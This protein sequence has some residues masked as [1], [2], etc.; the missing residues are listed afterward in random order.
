MSKKQLT[1]LTFLLWTEA[2]VSDCRWKKEW[3]CFSSLISEL[4]LSTIFLVN[5]PEI[6]QSINSQGALLQGTNV[7]GYDSSDLAG[8]TNNFPVANKIGHGGFGSAYK[9][10]VENGVEITVKMS[11]PETT[12]LTLTRDLGLLMTPS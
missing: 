11:H 4:A 10:V 3:T 8:A 6:N 5:E 2:L 1:L 12:P 7:I 9:G